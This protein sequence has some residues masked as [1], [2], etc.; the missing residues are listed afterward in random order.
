MRG[1]RRG[2]DEWEMKREQERR[3]EE[4]G[5]GIFPS[6]E[7]LNT[8]LNTCN[9]SLSLSLCVCVCVRARAFDK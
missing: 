9:V 4:E 7:I 6:L 2:Y 1:M 5:S 3:G 8:S